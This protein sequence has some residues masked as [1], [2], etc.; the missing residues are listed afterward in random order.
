MKSS[1]WKY[2]LSLVAVALTAYLILAA[3]K[4]IW[5]FCLRCPD[6]ACLNTESNCGV[7]GN[8]CDKL[9][10]FCS[11]Y[12]YG[13]G[14]KAGCAS[15]DCSRFPG[16]WGRGITCAPCPGSHGTCL[17]LTQA[18][19]CG[20]DC[21]GQL[22]C[23]ATWP[24][25]FPICT[26]PQTDSK[27]CGGCGNYC[28]GSCVGGICNCTNPAAPNKCQ[29]VCVNVKTDPSN[30]GAC[31]VRCGSGETC[32]DGGC[33]CPNTVCNG[34]CCPGLPVTVPY[35]SVSN[36]T[37]FKALCCNGS[38]QPAIESFGGQC[39]PSGQHCPPDSSCC[40]VSGNTYICCYNDVTPLGCSES[41]YLCS[42]CTSAT[43]CQ[44]L[45]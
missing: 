43:S 6:G 16:C 30:C 32:I 7:C 45:L 13:Y 33:R 41:P 15:W 5:P 18:N 27:N 26:D 12:G 20:K 1:I 3:L 44:D 23:P 4:H 21:G 14:T 28:N 42:V 10:A 2:L 36:P 8:D 38:C 19:C 35:P 40:G 22:C 31:G 9:G 37:V 11:T 24:Q 17:P 25:V 39:C 29:S 34:V